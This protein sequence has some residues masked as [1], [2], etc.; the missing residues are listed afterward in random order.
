MTTTTI[1]NSDDSRIAPYCS[2][3]DKQLAQALGLFVA[4]GEFLVRRLLISEFK[5]HSVLMTDARFHAGDWGVPDEVPVYLASKAIISEIVGFQFHRGV[6]ALGHRKPMVP[7]AQ[8][9][10]EVENL[11][12]LMICPEI[13]D[14]ENLGS[15]MRTGA[16]LGYGHFLL[17]PSCCDPFARRAIRTSMGT[18]FQLNIVRSQDLQ[19]DLNQLKEQNGFEWHASVI[20]EEAVPL[21]T[22]TP[23]QKVGLMFGSE[24]HGLAETW[25]QLA[26]QR[27]TIPMAL[28]TDSLNVSV[29]AGIF[30][31]HYRTP[32]Q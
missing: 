1:T 11:T 29:A 30:M 12:R 8:S 28:D 31:H 6:L 3:K 9:W 13:N 21:H 10:P 7:L 2:L 26:D 15:L 5:V 24:A 16:G 20:C 25:L 4:E 19:A 17:G 27:V 22:I 23:P 32:V 18:V 14:V